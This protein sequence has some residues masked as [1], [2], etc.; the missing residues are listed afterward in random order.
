MN[1]ELMFGDLMRVESPHLIARYNRALLKTCGIETKLDK[2]HIDCSGYSP[3][4]AE[5]FNAPDYLN[6]SGISK[7]FII[8]SIEQQYLPISRSHF[9][10]TSEIIQSFI[11]DNSKSLLTLTALDA[12]YGELENNI[13]RV[14]KLSDVI[15]AVTV[16]VKVNSTKN[17]IEVAKK[18]K[19]KMKELDDSN[20]LEW[21]K[22]DKLEKIIELVKVTGDIRNNQMIPTKVK[23]SKEYFYTKHYGGLYIFRHLPE[24]GKTTVIA[25]Q[26]LYDVDESD[27]VTIIQ[28]TDIRQVFEFLLEHGFISN[29]DLLK[30]TASK[31][32]LQEKKRQLVLDYMVKSGHYNY[33]DTPDTYEMSQFIHDNFETLPKQFHLFYE[34]LM[35][36]EKNQDIESIDDSLIFYLCRSSNSERGEANKKLIN[37]LITNY[38]PY[39]Y[40]TTFLY[41]RDLFLTQFDQWLYE[42]QV[43]IEQYLLNHVSEMKKNKL[44]FY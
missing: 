14:N 13:Y 11:R 43:Y 39:S 12:V 23:Y 4:I 44:E 24:R 34:L 40:L 9:S 22:S 27:D 33:E 26:P 20:D 18:L 36:I 41:N 6:A 21:M 37:H 19:T 35:K 7:R 2:F 25:L 38:T 16:K 28:S 17:F 1:Y 15:D 10:S 5:E 32:A 8:I 31:D 30:L 29:I 42:K 3:E